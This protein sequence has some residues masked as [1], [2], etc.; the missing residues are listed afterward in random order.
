MALLELAA[1]AAGAGI[2]AV[3][4]R[5]NLL[6]NG[7][8][9]LRFAA[10]PDQ[11]GHELHREIDVMK[12]QLEAGAEVVQAWLAIRRFDTHSALR[13]S[14]CFAKPILGALA[15]AGKAHVAF[16]AVTGQRVALVLAEL[17]L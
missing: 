1:T 5:E 6:Q 7:H 3:D 15:V 17:Q 12:E 13:A 2:V 14:G 4:V 10:A 9:L 8:D 11:A 16:A